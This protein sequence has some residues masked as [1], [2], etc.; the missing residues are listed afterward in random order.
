MQQAWDKYCSSAYGR[1]NKLDKQ[2]KKDNKWPGQLKKKRFHRRTFGEEAL[3]GGGQAQKEY[4][5]RGI[6]AHCSW[7]DIPEV[8]IRCV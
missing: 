4:G 8:H 2:Q 1:G 7:A 5:R 3:E 6:Q